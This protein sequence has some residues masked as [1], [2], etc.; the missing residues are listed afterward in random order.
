MIRTL[1]GKVKLKVPPGTQPGTVLRLAG[2]G[3]IYRGMRGDQLVH[4]EV[5]IP[6]SLTEEEK[7]IWKK[8]REMSS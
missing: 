7:S 5:G 8:L 6:E 4:I 1:D 3:I 2:K